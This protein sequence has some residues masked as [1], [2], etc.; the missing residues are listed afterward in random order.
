MLTDKQK[1][2][3]MAFAENDMNL[4]KTAKAVFYS[5]PNVAHYLRRVAAG[6]GLDPKKFYDLVDLVRKIKEGKL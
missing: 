5:A 6:T 2:F 4:E 3:V 1:V